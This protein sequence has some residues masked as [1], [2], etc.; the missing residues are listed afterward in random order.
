MVHLLNLDCYFYK[1]AAALR[2][3]AKTFQTSSHPKDTSNQTY[4]L[5]SNIRALSSIKKIAKG[6]LDN[7]AKNLL[8]FSKNSTDIIIEY[9]YSLI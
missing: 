3:S 1:T 7:T 8:K 2:K 4:S 9:T 5:K 6:I